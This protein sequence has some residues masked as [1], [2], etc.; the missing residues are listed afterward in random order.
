LANLDLASRSLVWIAF[1]GL[2][3]S[4]MRCRYVEPTI[5]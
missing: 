4:G 1:G 2:Q 5:V 3:G